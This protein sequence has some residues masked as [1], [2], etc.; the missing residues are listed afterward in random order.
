MNA[1]SSAVSRGV[2][3][4]FSG[5]S[6]NNWFI[7]LLLL[8]VRVYAGFVIMMKGFDKFPVSETFV[9]M[10]EAFQIQGTAI[11]AETAAIFAFLAA[12][13]E[14][15]GGIL[16]MIGLF[17]RWAAFFLAVTL[18][19][20]AYGFQST[21]ITPFI[22][23]NDAASLSWIFVTFL[24]VGPGVFSMDSWARRASTP[25]PDGEKRRSAGV[26]WLMFV[27]FLGA[28]GY[29]I[30]A[31]Y[32]A[33]PTTPV[34]GTTDGPDE[35][36]SSVGPDS[37][38]VEAVAEGSTVEESTHEDA[39]EDG[40]VGAPGTEDVVEEEEEP[41]EED[42][43]EETHSEE[44]ESSEEH[45]ESHEEHDAD[46]SHSAEEGHAEGAHEEEGAE[47]TPEEVEAETSEEHEPAEETEE[48][49]P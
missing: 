19:F 4:L 27:L 12:L 39:P 38:T 32:L 8:C 20:A 17:T 34:E 45:G 1:P 37:E 10:V 14:F 7:G 36:E 16:L 30:Y 46:E 25:L 18:G 28:I 13:A 22:E 43:P 21:S 40:G 23:L 41:S 9:G 6:S 33:A 2:G 49:A 15:S 44:V 11:F 29:P 26:F 5:S 35:G 42:S 47:V 3:F 48:E 31:Q 24:A